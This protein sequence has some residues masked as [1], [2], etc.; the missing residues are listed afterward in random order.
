MKVRKNEPIFDLEKV[1]LTIEKGRRSR[2][3]RRMGSMRGGFYY[4][5]AAGQKVT[6]EEHLER[7]RALVIPP[8][9]KYVRISPTAGSP[10][11][12]VGMDTTGRVQY[13]Y[14]RKFSEKRQREKF[15]K[16]ERFG[17][18]LPKL[19]EITNQHIALK[20]LPREKVLALMMRLINSLYIRVGSEKSVKRYKT[21]G[22]TTLEN[23]H[24]TIKA[25]GQ[26]V[27]EF[28]GKSHIQHRK[29]LVDTEIAAL[30]KQLKELG[31]GRKL[32]NYID[33]NGI[34]RSVQSYDINAYIKE[35]MATDFSSKDFRTW[36]GTILAATELA[37]MGPAAD[38]TSL[39]SN[40]VKAVKKV[41]AELG[42][43][44]SVCRSSYIHPKVIQCYEAGITI[45]QMQNSQLRR[46]R[47]LKI[48]PEPEEEALLR[49][50]KK[51]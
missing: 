7:I 14:N 4:S 1:R 16:L 11:Q 34:V 41:A 12:A 20:G 15:R 38:A 35:A 10:V 39:K 23:R 26:L 37:E 19:R 13:L 6:N 22:I 49:M 47:R 43:T 31:K 46:V 5:D 2:W 29:V 51:E 48:D 32:F 17:S 44:P 40:L 50:L 30:M 45:N 9:W 21:F 8:A 33:E 42:N 27:F 25:K 18:S 24:L 3:V 36:A 28:V